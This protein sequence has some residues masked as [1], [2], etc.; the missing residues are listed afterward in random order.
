MKKIILLFVLTINLNVLAQLPT[1]VPTNGLVGYWP[2]DGNANDL[3]LN[4]NNG[5]TNGVTLTNDRFGN[6]NS[7]YYFNGTSDFIEV[8]DNNS[9]DLSNEYTF[10]VWVKIDD[11]TLNTN[12][13]APQR[14]MLGKPTN[15]DNGGYSFRSMEGV[16]WNLDGNALEYLGAWNIPSVTNGT[17]GSQLD[18][19]SIAVW[20]NLIFTYDG[21]EAKL[22]KNGVLVNSDI[23]SFSLT[24]STQSLYFGKEFN[25]IT[26]SENRW[27][28]GTLDDIGIWNR[29][30]NQQEITEIFLSCNLGAIINSSN[31]Y[32]NTNLDIVL[33]GIS[34]DINSTFQW[35]TN[36]INTGWQNVPNNLNYS[37]ANS[38]SL[39][40]YNIQLANHL[41]PFRMIATSGICVDTSDIAIINVTDTCTITINDTIT[42]LISVTDTLIINSTLTGQMPPNNLNTIKV[43]PNPAN[44]H[45]TINYGN[46]TSMSGYNLKIVNSLSQVVFT[47]LI[48]QQLSYID[49]TTWNGNGIY[50]IQ[51][52]DSQ[53]NLLENRKIVL[54]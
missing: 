54:Q 29:A 33:N 7:S 6:N 14:T 40:L 51:I 22:F 13:S 11:Y 50:F 1:Y 26:P 20:T 36:P 2:F 34:N 25:S 44:D 4:G 27:F 12:M 3:S 10:S 30:L 39:T 32:T 47:T 18:S 24:N 21:N 31:F 45:I 9:L 19:L 28:K 48:S 52:F 5:L 49:L 15:P 16:D 43:Y 37:G 8:L 35:Q 38:N 42:T 41:Q 46:Y 17:L 53:N 23:F